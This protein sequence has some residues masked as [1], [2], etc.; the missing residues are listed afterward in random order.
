MPN[1]QFPAIGDGRY[2]NPVEALS[3]GSKVL[4]DA[5]VKGVLA[6]IGEHQL[7]KEGAFHVPG[8]DTFAAVSDFKRNFLPNIRAR[9]WRPTSCSFPDHG[10]TALRNGGSPS[11]EAYLA[12]SH[13]VHGHSHPDLLGVTLFAYGDLLLGDRGVPNYY[14]P[15][16]SEMRRSRAHST[17]IVDGE[18]MRKT[19]PSVTLFETGVGADLWQCRSDGY[20]SLGVTHTRT[21]AFLKSE[22][23]IFVI[24]D[25]VK[26]LTSDVRQL[27]VYYHSMQPEVL[28]ESPQR[29]IVGSGPVLT[30]ASPGNNG[31]LWQGKEWSIS[32]QSN[33]T[34]A[35]LPFLAYRKKSATDERFC[36][37]LAP[38]ATSPRNINVT[39][40]DDPSSALEIEISEDGTLNTVIVGKRT[41]VVSVSICERASASRCPGE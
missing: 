32:L 25:E 27:D 35:Q 11:D 16:T 40:E 10:L 12:V 18:D 41:G 17:L 2:G 22:R 9:T 31:T 24:V 8:L 4:R 23:P 30:I 28:V 37:V 15:H 20:E 39:W 5:E 1:G 6:R 19:R 29:V 36:S 26:R 7:G 14:G 3:L 13:G 21:I 34:A 38:D 33:M